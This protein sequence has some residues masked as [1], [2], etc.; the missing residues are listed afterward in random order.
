MS[1]VTALAGYSEIIRLPCLIEA[2]VWKVTARPPGLLPGGDGS[3]DRLSASGYGDISRRHR[4]L[5]GKRGYYLLPDMQLVQSGVCGSNSSR[6][7]GM[8]SPHWTQ[9]P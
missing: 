5:V 3:L 6:F 8:S 7:S 4:T 9:I 2:M 1:R